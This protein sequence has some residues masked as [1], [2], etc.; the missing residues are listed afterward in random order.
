MPASMDA[1][2]AVITKDQADSVLKLTE[3]HFR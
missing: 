1:G 3:Q 2:A